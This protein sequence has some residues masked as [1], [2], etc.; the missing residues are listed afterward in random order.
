MKFEPLKLLKLLPIYLRALKPSALRAY[1][2]RERADAFQQ[3]FESG[4]DK[5]HRRGWMQLREKIGKANKYPHE[6]TSVRN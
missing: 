5:G 4:F 3:G 2:Q 1:L 6:P